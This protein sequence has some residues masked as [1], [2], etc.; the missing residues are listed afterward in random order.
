MNS[1]N[2]L[3]ICKV[4]TQM[5][6]IGLLQIDSVYS[7]M[8][9]QSTWFY[10]CT[11]ET[12]LPGL[13]SFKIWEVNRLRA[14][15][16]CQGTGGYVKRFWAIIQRPVSCSW[17]TFHHEW[18]LDGGKDAYWRN[19]DGGTRQHDCWSSPGQLILWEHTLT[20]LAGQRDGVNIKLL[21]FSPVFS[22]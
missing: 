16:L 12:N 22:L 14:A 6:C 18:F 2:L 7:I 3:K 15:N 1:W 10:H 5:L 9:I 21:S 19:H 8:A 20:H 11:N 13:F 17:A 4:A